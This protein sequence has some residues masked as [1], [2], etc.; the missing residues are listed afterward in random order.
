MTAKCPECGNDIHFR[1]RVEVSRVARYDGD[2]PNYSYDMDADPPIV[3][4]ECVVCDEPVPVPLQ[5]GEH[6]T[7]LDELS[8]GDKVVWK[9][10][11]ERKVPATVT[12]R[13]HNVVFV[14]GP[15]GGQILF[16]QSDDGEISRETGS[17]V[18]RLT[19]V[20]RGGG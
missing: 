1:E 3:E 20:E 7:D 12:G 17:T 19:R 13:R 4:R 8:S 18:S 14:E 2:D 16:T 5:N 15:R 6:I 10:Q 9:D 11:I